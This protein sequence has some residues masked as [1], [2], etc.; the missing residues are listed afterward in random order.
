MPLLSVEELLARRC[1]ALEAIPEDQN[2]SPEGLAALLDCLY[3]WYHL[4]ETSEQEKAMLLKRMQLLYQLL[5]K[6][7]PPPVY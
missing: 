5:L 1:Q 3:S 2:T 6:A 7:H 4:P